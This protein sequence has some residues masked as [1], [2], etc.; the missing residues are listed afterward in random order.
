MRIASLKLCARTTGTIWTPCDLLSVS[1]SSWPTSSAT[2]EIPSL[3]SASSLSVVRFS[4]TSPFPFTLASSPYILSEPDATATLSSRTSSRLRLR[5]LFEVAD[6]SVDRSRRYSDASTS[7]S[8]GPRFCESFDEMERRF[9][10]ELSCS[11]SDLSSASSMPL[12]FGIY[13]QPRKSINFDTIT[14]SY[15]TLCR[16]RDCC[17]M[18]PV[19]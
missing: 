18:R 1:A 14:V 16:G 4:L 6:L 3:A 13:M 10:A 11:F 2:L 17:V 8:H 12:E 5:R 19:G 9:D 7:D 15:Y